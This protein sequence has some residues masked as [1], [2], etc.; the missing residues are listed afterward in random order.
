MQAP[1]LKDDVLCHGHVRSLYHRS[2]LRRRGIAGNLKFSQVSVALAVHLRFLIDPTSESPSR[3][4]TAMSRTVL[5]LA[6]SDEDDEM[7]RL[8]SFQEGF[9]DVA[10]ETEVTDDE[11]NAALTAADIESGISSPDDSEYCSES[12]AHSHSSPLISPDK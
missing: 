10:D 7:R 9:D 6:S 5:Q 1:V 3:E 8:P 2:N 11:I 12:V 4:A